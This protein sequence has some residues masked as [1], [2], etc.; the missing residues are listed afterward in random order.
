[1][2]RRLSIK[3]LLFI[4]CKLY[5]LFSVLVSRETLRT[6]LFLCQRPFLLFWQSRLSFQLS[7]AF[8]LPFVLFPCGVGLWLYV[9][10]LWLLA[11]VLCHLAAVSYLARRRTLAFSRRTLA[12]SRRTLPFLVPVFPFLVLDFRLK[13]IPFLRVERVFRLSSHQHEKGVY[14]AG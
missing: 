3:T 6:T 12:F 1:M 8:L 10:G 14:V 5:R 13:L 7:S 4:F 9:A 2:Q 11:A